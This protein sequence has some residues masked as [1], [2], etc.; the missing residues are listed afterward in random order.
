MPTTHRVPI[1]IDTAQDWP[2]EN[3]FLR[4]RVSRQPDNGLFRCAR[5]E[6]RVARREWAGMWRSESPWTDLSEEQV[7][8]LAE[9][10]HAEAARRYQ[11]GRQQKAVRKSRHIKRAHRRR[12]ARQ[13][14]REWIAERFGHLRDA[15]RDEKP[16]RYG[17]GAE[18]MG[19]LE[20]L[21]KRLDADE[22]A[23]LAKMRRQ[24]KEAY[25]LPPYIQLI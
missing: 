16:M 3:E 23:E 25:D 14:L 6:R 15:H 8:T 24:V 1:D 2:I 4:M 20:W 10:L 12:E 17:G 9:E 11:L 7:R 5:P 22:A 13:D 21:P 19:F 18:P